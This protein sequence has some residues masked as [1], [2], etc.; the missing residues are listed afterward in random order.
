ML[1]LYN[2]NIK[3]KEKE[4]WRFAI[5][6]WNHYPHYNIEECCSVYWPLFNINSS[7]EVEYFSYSDFCRSCNGLET[8]KTTVHFLSS[9]P[10]S[11]SKHNCK[12]SL[13]VISNGIDSTQKLHTIASIA[14]D[15]IARRPDKFLSS[16]W[17][18]TTA[19]PQKKTLPLRIK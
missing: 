6:P 18:V 19:P 7:V 17:C 5:L 16:S 2:K 4:K 11:C 14:V 3:N 1:V 9:S 15:F 12:E 8:D 10:S 13:W